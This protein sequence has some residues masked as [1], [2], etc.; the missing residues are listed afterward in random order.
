ME[1]RY[2][3]CREEQLRILRACHVDPTAGHM[4]VNKT[5]CK[6][7]E[8]FMWKG[9]VNDVKNLVRILAEDGKIYI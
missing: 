3:R 6:I 1:L 2:I 7:S 4:G 9:I 5:I 8:R